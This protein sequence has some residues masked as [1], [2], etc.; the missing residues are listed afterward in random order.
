MQTLHLSAAVLRVRSR[1]GAGS[2]S[3]A[4][5]SEQW[6]EPV[7]RTTLQEGSSPSSAFP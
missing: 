7:G 5:P 1:G 2:L 4:G 6:K 3:R